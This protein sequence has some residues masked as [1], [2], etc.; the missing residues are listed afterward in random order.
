MRK[1]LSQIN[2]YRFGQK[3]GSL[4]SRDIS[5]TYMFEV[6]YLAKI[7]IFGFK[8]RHYK[9]VE[10]THYM[11]KLEMEDN[12]KKLLKRVFKNGTIKQFY[13]FAQG[14]EGEIKEYCD[15]LN[16][17]VTA[18]TSNRELVKL[19]KHWLALKG[20]TDVIV[21]C[22][23]FLVRTLSQEVERQAAEYFPRYS[24][25]QL[26]ECLIILAYNSKET[27]FFKREKEILQLAIRL[28]KYRKYRFKKLPQK[29]QKQISKFNGKYGWMSIMFLIRH[30][31]TDIS[32][33]E[34]IQGLQKSNPAKELKEMVF[35]KQETLS[36]RD[37]ILKSVKFKEHFLRTLGLLRESSWIEAGIVKFFQLSSYYSL[38]FLYNL[39]DRLG[40]PYND[41]ICLKHVEIFK[42]L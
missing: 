33:W 4:L 26:K 42:A 31:I 22:G 6:P 15:Y 13:K 27:V 17:A 30:S 14:K 7:P 41:L 16:K 11:D 37:V 5:F 8:I 20:W 28:K 12:F 39:S 40:I 38:P 19:F 10:W 35:L 34:E 23:N 36:Q 25:R 21:P 1:K 3:K 9:Y 32:L 2:W 24:E 18:E 29:I